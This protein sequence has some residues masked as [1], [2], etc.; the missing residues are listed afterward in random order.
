MSRNILLMVGGVLVAGAA[1]LYINFQSQPAVS[2][3]TPEDTSAIEAGAPLAQVNIPSEFTSA[4]M[5]GQRIFDAKCAV[6]HGANAAGQN[7]VAPPLIDTIYR[8]GHHG[9]GAF[10]SAAMNGVTAHHWNFGNMPKIDGVTRADIKN[11][12]AY[13]REL[14]RENGIN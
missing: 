2:T 12:V 11:V 6:C 3:M 1:V 8:P 7:D 4:A 9:E 10:I 14:Q 13:I 5:L